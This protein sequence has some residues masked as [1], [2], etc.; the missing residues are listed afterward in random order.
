MLEMLI[1]IFISVFAEN[2]VFG[3]ALGTDGLDKLAKEPRRALTLGVLLAIVTAVTEAILWNLTHVQ[4]NAL[5]YMMI[6]AAPIVAAGV[7]AVLAF[8][9]NKLF[10]DTYKKIRQYMVHI[11][12]NTAVVGILCRVTPQA[13]SL[14][15]SVVRA[16]L[17]AVGVIFAYVIFASIRERIPES[18]QSRA[19]RGAPT[20]LIAAG[21]LAMV[22]CGF[23][24]MRI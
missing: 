14:V 12:L 15:D 1:L 13:E 6:V 20:L 4:T 21:L 11:A 9:M 5:Q 19:L 10:S 17:S 3:S 8:I 24:G 23:Y 2:A 7:S 22:F 16:A 18:K